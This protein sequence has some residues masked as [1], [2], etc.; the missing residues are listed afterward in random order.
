MAPSFESPNGLTVQLYNS[1]P[2]AP[3]VGQSPVGVIASW[4]SGREK[5]GALLVRSES[6]ATTTAAAG[7]LLAHESSSAARVLAD[8]LAASASW[9]LLPLRQSAREPLR[10]WIP[11]DM[12]ADRP[13]L[14][15]PRRRRG[16]ATL[17]GAG[18]VVGDT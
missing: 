17:R 5:I 9:S 6:H 14:R 1:A 12:F 3:P 18:W 16:K 8:G 4:G 10:P 15:P 2:Q 11:S 7:C 13:V